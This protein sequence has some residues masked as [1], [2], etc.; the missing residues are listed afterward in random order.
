MDQHSDTNTSTVFRL[1]HHISLI[2]IVSSAYLYTEQEMY[3]KPTTHTVL[4]SCNHCCRGKAISIPYSE[5]VS[6]ALL[7]QHAKR[8]HRIFIYNLTL[9]I[10]SHYLIKDAIFG[11]KKIH[12][13]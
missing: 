6:V 7:I 10:L 4:L 2:V 3:I 13:T 5:C 8:M 11:K 12:R 9:P 1:T